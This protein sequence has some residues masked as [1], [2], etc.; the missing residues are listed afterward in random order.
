MEEEKFDIRKFIP[1]FNIYDLYVY[2]KDLN[3]ITGNVP[4]DRQAKK[5][6]KQ[7]IGHFNSL[8]QQL[9]DGSNIIQ[10]AIDFLGQAAKSER[11]KEINAIKQYKT[12]LNNELKDWKNAP[13]LKEI[14][15]ELE[16]INLDTID[17]KEY[18]NFNLKLTKGINL[19]KQERDDYLARLERILASNKKNNFTTR[20]LFGQQIQY[21]LYGDVEGILKDCVGE[22]VKESKDEEENV[23]KTLRRC[24]EDYVFSDK[25]K[26]NGFSGE[27]IAAFMSAVA[28]DISVLAQQEFNKAQIKNGTIEKQIAPEVVKKVYEQYKNA[29][30]E[31][32]TLLQKAYQSRQ[33]DELTEI[34]GN[35][36]KAFGIRS[37]SLSADKLQEKKDEALKRIKNSAKKQRNEGAKILQQSISGKSIFDKLLNVTISSKT[38]GI[39]GNIEE[40]V[41]SIIEKAILT[42]G[43]TATDSLSIGSLHF[44]TEVSQNNNNIRNSVRE[45]RDVIDFFVN[46]SIIENRFDSYAE[47]YSAMNDKLREIINILKQTVIEDPDLDQLF[48]FHES[49]KSYMG[50]E[51]NITKKKFNGFHGVQMAIFTAFDR[52]YSIAGVTN[53]QFMQLEEIKFIA[54]NLSSGALEGENNKLKLEKYLSIFAGL[55]MFDDIKNI[56][57]DAARQLENEPVQ[58]VHLYLLN[59]IYVPSSV[60]L[61]NIYQQLQE[62]L[63]VINIDTAAKITISTAGIDKAIEEYNSKKLSEKGIALW[64]DYAEKARKS[65]LITIYFL[66]SFVNFLNKLFNM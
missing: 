9:E 31:S 32:M 49:I 23:A 35:M 12:K 3:N 62:G 33:Q 19:I 57:I 24:A 20:E 48:I 51:G 40:G 47:E 6:A 13:M 36:K 26:L 63:Q 58:E 39:H 17:F 65:T 34:L 14:I 64:N 50:A 8:S 7:V 25:K 44:D 43:K 28:V 53:L 2:F 55:L 38:T 1:D 15:D 37:L 11:N 5:V 10:S 61:T 18:E 52:L 45:M 29:T 46:R 16:K 30:N 60:I 22:Y 21:R 56:A 27:D 59:N 42:K 66:A 54:L 41:H 4:R